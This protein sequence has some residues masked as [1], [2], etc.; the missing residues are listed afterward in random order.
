MKKGRAGH[1]L[2]VL[3]T[4][5]TADDLERAMFAHTTTIGVRRA[6]VQ[7]TALRREEVTVHVD[8]E[9]VRAKVVLGPDGARRAKP[10]SED[11]RRAAERLGRSARTVLERATE[12]LSKL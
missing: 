1:R 4:P 3:A 9:P 12:E 11:V 10:E 8:G 2:E 7:R 5:A 6:V